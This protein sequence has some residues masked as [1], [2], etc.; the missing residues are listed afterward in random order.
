MNRVESSTG[1]IRHAFLKMSIKDNCMCIKLDSRC[2]LT[3]RFMSDFRTLWLFLMFFVSFP[4]SF[5]KFLNMI[6]FY[7]MRFY[8][9]DQIYS[10]NKS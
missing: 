10:F 7:R 9:C 8:L 5:L 2:D 4:D 6:R 3:L 1:F